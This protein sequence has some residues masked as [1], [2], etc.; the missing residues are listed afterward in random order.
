MVRGG[1]PAGQQLPP[2][3]EETREWPG[4][5]RKALTPRPAATQ[6]PALDVAAHPRVRKQEA[7]GVPAGVGPRLRAQP[8]PR[9][10]WRP[11]KMN[12]RPAWIRVH[13]GLAEQKRTQAQET[14][15]SSA[16]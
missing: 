14:L 1:G 16:T 6:G 9:H 5:G 12:T 7:A 10:T 3:G 11:Q 8:S 2:T 13:A 4:V 15:K